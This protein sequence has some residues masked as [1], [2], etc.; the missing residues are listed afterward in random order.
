M[1]LRDGQTL[2]RCESKEGKWKREQWRQDN[3]ET[4]WETASSPIHWGLMAR[5]TV[6][7]RGV[8]LKRQ[9]KVNP[10]GIPNA[11]VRNPWY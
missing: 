6:A 4:G 1:N 5:K 11:K 2:N 8:G 7:G 9:T 10:L 3:A